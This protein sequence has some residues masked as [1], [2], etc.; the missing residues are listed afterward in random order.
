ML[1][2]LF[3]FNHKKLVFDT[4]AVLL[5][6]SLMIVALIFS[7]SE[8]QVVFWGLAFLIGGMSKAIEGVQKTIKEKSLN[9]E[10]LMIAASLAAFFTGEYA[11]GAT[12]IFIFAVSGVLEEFATA[13]SEQA[14]TNL[15]KIA[16]KNAIKLEDGKEVLVDIS[17]LK[18]GDFVLVKTGQQCPADGVITEGLASFDQSSIT[19]E[20]L[21]NQKNQ[22]DLVY[23]GSISV[24]ATVTVKVTKDPSES[25]VQKMIDLVKKAQEEKTKAEVRITLFEK[26]Y[27]Y[28]VILLSL[29]VIFVPAQL[30]WLAAQEAFRRGII[31]LVV[32][33]PCA[34]VASIT[35][36]ILSTISHGAKKGI[37]VKSGRYLEKVM[38]TDVVMFDKTGTI[39]SGTPKVENFLT[40]SNMDRELILSILVS[41]EAQSTHPLAVAIVKHFS[42]VQSLTVISKEIPGRGL[43]AVVDGVTWSIG[44]FDYQSHAEGQLK[45]DEARQKGLTVVMI[46]REEQLVGFVALK[47]TVRKNV[48]TAIKQLIDLNIRPVM[49]TGDNEVTAQSIANEV[50]IQHFYG[51][52]LPEDKVSIIK[53]Y[54]SRGF[55]VLMIGDGINDA[56][57]LVTSDVGVAMGDGTDVSLETA[58]I[59]MM[60]NDLTNIPYLVKI[61]KNMKKIINQNVI[62]SISVITIL[63]VSNLFGLILLTY[64]V[65]GHELSTILVVLN[66]LRL[67]KIT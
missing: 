2:K 50:G 7:N 48:S 3:S 62:F 21:P 1:R 51:N 24:D 49:L 19:G 58:D 55:K 34:L 25:V 46:I 14:L 5:S 64:G 63:L 45:L 59:V 65:F 56:P 47:D 61:T 15:L 10:F 31:V 17:S 27:V 40:F 22:G 37:L 33:S 11:E 6:L 36:A 16:P 29:F 8:L 32:A 67:L 23:A 66:S 13:Q 44:K 57:S 41:L 43:Q 53:E 52:C 42:Q 54:Q 35:P 60:N 28:F 20:F 9:V 30:G 39:T 38:V 12:L 26:I 18:V 4:F